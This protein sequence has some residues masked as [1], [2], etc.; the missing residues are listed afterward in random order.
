[1]TVSGIALLKGGIQGYGKIGTGIRKIDRSRKWDNS[2]EG[3]Y[4]KDKWFRVVTSRVGNCWRVSIN[5][6][7]IKM[8]SPQNNDFRGIILGDSDICHNPILNNMRDVR[9][10]LTS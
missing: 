4:H 3:R 9:I 1:M 2:G 7:I 5:I 6:E 8:E 10:R